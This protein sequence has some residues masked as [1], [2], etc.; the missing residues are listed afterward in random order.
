MKHSL[1]YKLM[2]LFFV[3]FFCAVGGLTY[4]AYTSSRDAMLQEF[5]IRGRSLAKAI[6]SES[7]TYYRN[8]DVEG[9]TTL[10][11]SLGETEDVLAILTYRSPK[12]LWIEFA[13]IELTAEDLSLNETTDTWQQDTVLAKGHIVSEFGNAVA[14]PAKANLADRQ[15]AV[16]PD[17]WIR[18]FLDRQALERR[19][20][21]LVIRT[22]LISGLTV[23]LGGTLFTWLLRQSLHVIG[24]LTAA[25]K[26]VAQG[27]LRIIVPVSSHDELGELAQGFN[28]M[29]EQL[30][31]T[32]VSKNYVDNIIRSM[33][34][35][36]I[37]VSPD[38]AIASVNR[39][40]LALLGYEEHELLGQHITVLLPQ[41]EPASS[42]ASR[43][44]LVLQNVIG[45][46][47]TTYRTKDGR[48]IPMLLS[49]AVMRDEDGR[50]T[51]VARVAK[52]MTEHKQT[53]EQLRLRGAAL[54]SAANTVVITDRRGRITW[55]NPSFAALTGYSLEEAIGQD[56]RSLKAG[57][58][59][60]AF[61]QN[62]WDTIVSG[63][64]WQGEVINRKKDGSLY[65]EEETIT[66]V[67]DQNR[68]ISHFI[69]IKQDVTERK[70]AEKALIASR[71]YNRT[72]FDLSPIGLALFDVDGSIVDCNEA[73][74]EMVG[75][76]RSEVLGMTYWELTPKTYDEQAR[77]I[78]D[79][80]MK[81]GYF[82]HYE[83]HYIHRDGHL[84]PVRLF[85]NL[86]ERDNDLYIFCSVEDITE[87]R[88]GEEALKAAHQK[89][90][91]LNET[92]SEFLANISHE[93]RTPLTVI[94]GEAEVTIRGKDKPIVE[95]KTT[96]ERI[97]HL[98]NQVNQLVGDLLFISRSESGTIE[99]DKQPTPLP[100]ILL[101]MYQEA[102]VLA[103]KK[104]I[105]VT[106]TSRNAPPIIVNGDSQRLR[107]LFMIIIT[108]AINYTKPE[109]AIT[110][111]L[112]SDGTSTRITVADNGIGIPE[113]DLPHVFQRFYRVKQRRQ[114]LVRSGSGLGLPIA[115]WIAEAHNGTVSIASVLN[116]G[117]TV[118]IEL[119]LHKPR[120]PR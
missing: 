96:L 40:A 118:T 87:R 10:L 99:I 84:V 114:D 120:S 102:R 20:D 68:E 52:D 91:E 104:H 56:L 113:E 1:L 85:G 100:E 76:L 46:G 19:L 42:E 111:N 47:E 106:L 54:E 57:Q 25:T 22:L 92:R 33:I 16:S 109:G 35:T 12:T 69:S 97:V 82:E 7:R 13:G 43:E 79:T 60:Q 8:R 62:L 80:I 89:L 18:V 48:A 41:H 49:E 117:T 93:L 58:H 30:L 24:P 95:Y 98:T 14:D 2:A 83:K 11:Q 103:E 37:V 34:D 81:T 28:S 101:E 44:D 59:N 65:T 66:P 94:R 4:F 78:M 90:T 26:K 63:N 61:D 86:I 29:T 9:F 55:A 17:G 67:Y 64:V 21:T 116:R 45:Q 50:I 36:L 15:E 73:Y 88:K 53:E 119:P 72:L 32:T 115:K 107:Q 112:D 110:V 70:Q 51:G 31:A 5:K 23:M 71:E 6:A 39:A 108:N 3:V 27:D 77:K 75:R 74:A 38:G 105:A